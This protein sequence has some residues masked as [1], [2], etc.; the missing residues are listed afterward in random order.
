MHPQSR[1]LVA[2]RPPWVVASPRL[3]TGAPI[4]IFASPPLL[5]RARQVTAAR[6]LASP[7]SRLPSWAQR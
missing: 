6:S 5:P 4:S 3:G 2:A 1:R 7:R